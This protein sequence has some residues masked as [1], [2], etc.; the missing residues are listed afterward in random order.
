MKKGEKGFKNTSFWVINSKKFAAGRGF[1]PPH[2]YS[3][4]ITLKK[5][6]K[7]SRGGG[8][9]DPPCR[10]A[11]LSP[12]RRKLIRQGKKILSKEGGWGK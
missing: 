3:S 7:N 12:A 9:S 4:E 2:T 10:R 1:A 5:F 11:G 6:K 8:S